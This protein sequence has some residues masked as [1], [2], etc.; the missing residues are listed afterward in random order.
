MKKV[1]YYFLGLF[2]IV[3]LNSCTEQSLDN[4]EIQDDTKTKT[5]HTRPLTGFDD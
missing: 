4:Y 1:V 5:S 2:A 3:C